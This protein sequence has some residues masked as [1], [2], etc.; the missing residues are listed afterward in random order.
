MDDMILADADA[1]FTANPCPHTAGPYMRLLREAEAEGAL[2]DDEF[3]NGLASIET[4][5]CA[6]PLIELATPAERAAAEELYGSDEIEF[7]DDARVSHADD[8]YWVGAFVWVPVDEEEAAECGQCEGTGRIE[9]GQGPGNEDEECPV[10]NGTGELPAD[11]S[12]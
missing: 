10:C 6:C 11:G 4:M 7:D 8:G 9:A 2:S 5:L 12:G 1:A 3:Q